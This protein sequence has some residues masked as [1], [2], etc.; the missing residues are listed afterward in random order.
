M[1]LR[2]RLP[3]QKPS[4]SSAGELM[5]FQEQPAKRKRQLPKRYQD[6]C[7]VSELA[8]NA[9]RT[10][11]S[12]KPRRQSVAGSVS[13]TA[14]GDVDVV[15]DDN[16]GDVDDRHSEHSRS[17]QRSTS[18]PGT[19][20]LPGKATSD[21]PPPRKKARKVV[22]SDS[23]EEEEYVEATH[24]VAPKLEEDDDDDD[25][26][27]FSLAEKPVMGAKGKGKASS[28]RTGSTSKGTKRKAKADP[29]EAPQPVLERNGSTK[30]STTARKRLKPQLKL[31]DTFIDV[32]GDSASTPEPSATVEH[33]PA[34]TKHESPVPAAPPKKLK[35]P[36]IKKTKL[37]GT[38]G[39]NT[40][41]SA[42]TSRKPPLEIGA[43]NKLNHDGVRK[44]LMGK[45]DIDLSNKSIYQEL[46]LKTG[47]VDG[48]TPRRAKEEE[49]R[50]E[51]NRMR[52]EAI[53]RRSTDA[54]QS[55]D[56]QAQFDKISRFEE[57]LRTEHSSALYPNFMAAKW[58]EV[59]ERDK[60]R[61]KSQEWNESV[62]ANGRE[63]GEVS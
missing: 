21:A 25:D 9:P 19:T 56:L 28:G 39:L 10:L 23:E 30:S 12:S 16:Q 35:L 52:D 45:T 48:G 4:S 61:Q 63:E 17:T 11:T 38:S 44:N 37:P 8:N 14:D 40:P 24:D 49:R 57:K 47:S 62:Y 20:N 27:Y 54:Q 3:A 51:L 46:F 32:V 42:T 41:T 43:N 34:T 18:Q 15:N 50:K 26:D 55:F 5:E 1:S 7:D 31:D 58:R 22:V 59:Y 33:S 53:A 13:T 6:G 2:I 60:R 29:E 36:T